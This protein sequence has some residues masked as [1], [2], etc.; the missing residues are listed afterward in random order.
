MFL[1][2]GSSYVTLVDTDKALE[3][4]HAPAAVYS[5]LSLKLKS[6]E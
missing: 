6:W 1:N 5:Q 4:V 2:F 3:M